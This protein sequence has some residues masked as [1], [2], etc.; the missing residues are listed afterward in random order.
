LIQECSKHF[1]D[2]PSTE[3]KAMESM[4]WVTAVLVFIAVAFVGLSMLGSWRWSKAT[5]AL[6]VRL[7]KARQ[8]SDTLRFQISEVENLPKPVQRY[9]RTALKDGQRMIAAVRLNHEGTFNLGEDIDNWKAF[10]SEQWVLTQRP[11]FVWNGNVTMMPGVPIYVH[12]AYVSGEGI[13]NPAILGLYNLT[14]IRGGGDIAKGEFMRFFAEALWYPTAL[15][16]S[17][18]VRWEAVDDRSARATLNDGPISLTMLFRFNDDGLVGSVRADARGRAVGESI[19]MTPWEI[20]V[21]D[22]QER[23]GM[24]VPLRGEV[25][26]FTPQ[27]TKPY[28]R[29]A[30]KKITFEYFGL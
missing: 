15:L 26:W 23:D 5:V 28:W 7:D 19:V 21:S 4:K 27:G 25:A 11:G 8:S 18:G 20:Q 22:Y 2:S 12:D 3:L 6:Q 17:Q 13:L 30:I 16:P 10:T 29:G 14:N 9:F 24:R 1:M